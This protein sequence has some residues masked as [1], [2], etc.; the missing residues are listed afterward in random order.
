V[1]IRVGPAAESLE[2]L[3][4]EGGQPFDLIFLDADK[5][6]YPVYLDLAIKLSRPG[7]LILADN[8][9]REGAIVDKNTTDERVVGVKAF[10]EKVGTHPRL[11]ATAIQTVGSKGYDGFAF[12]V[13]K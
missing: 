4:A 3:H 11:D 6:S 1:E 12:A 10:L 13:V 5:Q 7:T 8:V 2:K 9:V